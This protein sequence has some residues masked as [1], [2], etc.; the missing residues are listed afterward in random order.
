VDELFILPSYKQNILI[1]IVSDSYTDAMKRSEPL[2]WRARVDLIAEYEPLLPQIKDTTPGVT[3]FM[4]HNKSNDRR[5]QIPPTWQY[6]TLQFQESATATTVV[7]GIV[8]FELIFVGNLRD[9][10]DTYRE[11]SNANYSYEPSFYW[12]LGVSAIFLADILL[13]YYTW[14]HTIAVIE[15]QKSAARSHVEAFSTA[16]A[17]SK[18]G[19]FFSNKFRALDSFLVVLDLFLFIIEIVLVNSKVDGKAT[20][21]LARV[22][23]L[24]RSA[25][26][27]GRLRVLRSLRFFHRLGVLLRKYGQPKR[28]NVIYS[29]RKAMKVLEEATDG[30]EDAST[31]TTERIKADLGRNTSKVLEAIDKRGSG[32]SAIEGGNNGI[33]AIIKPLISDM[34]IRLE[35]SE[36]TIGALV[37]KIDALEAAVER[38]GLVRSVPKSSELNSDRAHDALAQGEVA[39]DTE[40]LIDNRIPVESANVGEVRNFV[41]AGEEEEKREAG[42]MESDESSAMISRDTEACL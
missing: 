35:S 42:L 3:D 4:T 23:R 6:R 40:D 16:A 27:I 41:K 1:A 5:T 31:G 19:G 22:F 36:A 38:N 37:S 32:T 39:E 28:Q 2:F 12:G 30:W 21:K 17:T 26:W 13:R 34:T 18:I 33:E 10:E 11:Q 7:F 15:A 9:K 25:K 14:S 24:A 29:L 20:S 8:L